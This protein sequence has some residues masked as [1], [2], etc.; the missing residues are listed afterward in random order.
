MDRVGM[1]ERDLEPEHPAARRL[2]DELRARVGE[3]GERSAN[4]VN[5]VR[6]VVHPGAA[7]REE[8]ADRRVL[9][10]RGQKLEPALADADGRRLD[11]LLLHA[12]AMLE[13]RAE[14]ALVRVER[15]VEILD[16]ETDVMHGARRL[17]GGDRI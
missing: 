7:L 17:H 3:V 15:A 12:R 5:L 13:P 8:A 2:V 11:A 6:D 10:K 14:E 9:A 1:D 4:V 16:R